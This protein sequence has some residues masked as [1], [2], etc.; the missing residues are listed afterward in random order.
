MGNYSINL[1]SDAIITHIKGVPMTFIPKTPYL[2]T[3]G[4]IE[5]YEGEEFKG[6]VLIERKH[7]PKS[8]EIPFAKQL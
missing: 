3:D 5:I 6:I 2:A 4:V 8:M 7:E 1:N